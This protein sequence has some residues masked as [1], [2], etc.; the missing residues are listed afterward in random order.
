MRAI[1]T[2]VGL[3][4]ALLAILLLHPR[5]TLNKFSDIHRCKG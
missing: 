1:S 3:L 5:E 2:L 4:I